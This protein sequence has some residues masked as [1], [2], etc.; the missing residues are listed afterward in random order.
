MPDVRLKQF[1]EMRGADSGPADHLTALPAFWAGLLY[2]E[3]ALTAAGD[4]GC[5]TSLPGS[6]PSSGS[7]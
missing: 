6:S 3:W 1:L 4:H 7:R 5:L 2:D